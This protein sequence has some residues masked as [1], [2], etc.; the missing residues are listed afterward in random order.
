MPADISGSAL[1]ELKDWLGITRPNEDGLLTNLLRS[2]LDTCEAFTGQSPLSQRIEER[3]PTRRGQYRIASVPVETLEAIEAIADDGTRTALSADMCEVHFEAAGSAVL[4][5]HSDIEGKAVA[6]TMQVG[7]AAQW[8]A[9]PPAIRQGL[10]RL[11][12]HC[13]RDRDRQALQS[14]AAT[15]PTSVTALWRP[16]RVVRLR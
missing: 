8:E 10:I 11:S 4:R 14:N 9:I 7:L 16:W 5:L 13:Y 3:L 2:S 15:P 6:V 12:A 1:A